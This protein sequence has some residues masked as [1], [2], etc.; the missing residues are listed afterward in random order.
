M[1]EIELLKSIISIIIKPTSPW[2]HKNHKGI[3]TCILA[4]KNIVYV[5]INLLY[6]ICG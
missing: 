4:Y 5:N 6:E 3:D 1:L 2:V